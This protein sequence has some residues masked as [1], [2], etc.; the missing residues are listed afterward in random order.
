MPKFV[1]DILESDLNSQ[2][3]LLTALKTMTRLYDSLW[4]ST[5]IVQTALAS[6]AKEKPPGW[7]P[8]AFDS[9]VRATGSDFQSIIYN[10]MARFQKMGEEAVKKK[11]RAKKRK[12]AKKKQEEGFDEE[13]EMEEEEEP[14]QETK[15]GTTGKSS[16]VEAR[17]LPSLIFA[18]E[19]YEQMILRIS[20]RKGLHNLGA[21]MKRSTAR[22]FRIRLD[23]ISKNTPPKPSQ[24]R[25]SQGEIRRRPLAAMQEED[26]EEAEV[27]EETTNDTTAQGSEESSSPIPTK[28]PATAKR[29][30]LLPSQ[31]YE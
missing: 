28:T 9:L 8:V 20:K 25:K 5:R 7:L 22:D 24:V 3:V 19:Q 11:V 17:L 21:N 2:Q 16:S 13:E 12:L 4:R 29:R 30:R 14:E 10:A 23:V 26:E 6:F 15:Q 18:I 1:L 27:E 31:N